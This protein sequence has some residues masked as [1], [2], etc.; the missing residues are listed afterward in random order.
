MSDGIKISPK[1]GLNPTIPICFWCGKERGEIAMLG[2][3]RDEYGNC[4]EAPHSCVI[5]YEPC[6]DCREKMGMGVTLIEATP[7]PKMGNT[8]A[9]Q[10]GAYPT[11]NWTVIK[12]EAAERARIDGPAAFVTPEVLK[13]LL[14]EDYK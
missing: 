14:G 2:D 11:G 8:R 4:V 13:G 6:D 10:P 12:K 5:D 7:T 3:I 9:I 1:Y